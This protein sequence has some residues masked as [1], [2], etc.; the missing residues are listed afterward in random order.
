MFTGIIKQIGEIISVS[1][2]ETV[3]QYTIQ[4]EDVQNLEIGAS[5]AIDGVCLTAV[6]IDEKSRQ[7]GFDVIPETLDR[8][9]LGGLSQGDKVNVERSLKMGDE[10][11]GHLVSGHVFCKGI[12]NSNRDNGEAVD[13]RIE[14]P[15]SV[16]KYIAE[17]GYIAVDG[18]S[19]TIGK[20]EQNEFNLHIIPETQIAT[21]LCSKDV[22]NGVNIEIDT[23]TMNIVDT[24]ERILK[25]RGL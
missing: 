13:L 20:V 10:L 19:L 23:M 21:T 8:T 3:V 1:H 16:M 14:V 25:E 11:G 6:K 24:T 5:V 4:I 15:P 17:K 22:G 7:V 18:I 12:I 2:G 9:T